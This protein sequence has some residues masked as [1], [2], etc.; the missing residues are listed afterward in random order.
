MIGTESG[1]MGGIRGDYRGLFIGGAGSG[2]R[3]MGRSRAID[4]EQLWKFVRTYDYVAGDY[5]WTGIDYL[6]E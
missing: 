1:S 3:A 2:F 6:G 4:V 5:M